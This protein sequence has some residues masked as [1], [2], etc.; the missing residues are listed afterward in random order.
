MGPIAV[1]AKADQ[2][3]ASS[4]LTLTLIFTITARVVGSQIDDVGDRA[5]QDCVDYKDIA[6]ACSNKEDVRIGGISDTL[7]VPL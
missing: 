4:A 5:H 7:R 1:I 2:P 6:M 3:V